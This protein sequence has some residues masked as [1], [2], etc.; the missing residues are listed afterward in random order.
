MLTFILFL[1]LSLLSGGL[2]CALGQAPVW[3][4]LLLFL[5]VFVGLHV[6]YILFF[7]FGSLSSDNKKPLSKQNKISRMACGQLIGLAN[8]YM[9]VRA[10]II[11]E[12]ILPKDQ[13]FLL[14]CNH[15]TCVDPLIIMDKLRKYNISF[16]SKPSNMEMPFAGRIAYGAGFLPIDRENNRNALKTIL[17][18]ADYI[19]RDICSMAVYPEGTRSRTNEL[20]PFHAGSFKI[21]QKA[22]CPLVICS[23]WGVEKLRFWRYIKG[24][25]VYLKVLDVLSAEK[26]KAMSTGEL[27]DYSRNII[28][29]SLKEV[30]NV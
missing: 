26:V 22:G 28:E 20:L 10:H 19:K 23:V 16:I 7:Y 6:L 15:R 21:A 18:A 8:I 17:T 30:E 3:Q 13:R 24:N 9:A 25:D 5:G 14:V 27:A 12:D 11:N 1:G 2:F 4:G 29:E